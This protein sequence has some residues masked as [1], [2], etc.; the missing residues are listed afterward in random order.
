MVSGVPI[1]RPDPM[2]N[3]DDSKSS[4]RSYVVQT[5]ADVVI[6]AKKI[7]D[8]FFDVKVN[9]GVL[10]TRVLRN[11]GLVSTKVLSRGWEKTRT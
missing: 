2:P 4:K 10:K 5:S 6:H 9:S 8:L 7:V 11:L 1:G 3:V